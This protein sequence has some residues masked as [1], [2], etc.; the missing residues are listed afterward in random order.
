MN[1]A[2]IGAGAWGSALAVATARAGHQVLLW[3]FDG[4]FDKFTDEMPA[5]ITPTTNLADIAPAD[6]WMIVTPAQFF[7]QTAA[8]AA[9]FYQGQPILI[10]TKGLARGNPQWM[11]ELLGESIKTC[12]DMAVVSGPQFAGEVRRGV[13]TGTLIAGTPR[14]REFGRRA[15]SDFYLQES[16]D[17]IGAQVCGVGKNAV[18]LVC[19]Y[20]SV[21]AAGENERAMILTRA[22]GEVVKFGLAAGGKMETFLGLAGIGDLFLSATSPTS[23]NFSGGA[24]MA[25]GLRVDGTVEGIGAMRGLIARAQDLGVQMPLLTQIAQTIGILE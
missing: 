24:A 10:C 5:G 18:A 21:T 7:A 16:D 25:R 22:W 2:I 17:I 20:A 15:L 6:L 11:S 13:P 3:S 14:A 4:I 19:G 8:S 9:P 1:I 23:R 12:V